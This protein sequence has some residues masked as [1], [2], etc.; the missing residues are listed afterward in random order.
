MA[1]CGVLCGVSGISISHYQI[2]LLVKNCGF[3]INI[4]SEKKVFPA[5]LY[6]T[7]INTCTSVIS[8]ILIAVL[9]HKMIKCHMLMDSF[10]TFNN[11]YAASTVYRPL[12]VRRW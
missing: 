4:F 1:W 5:S 9:P 2:S 10:R 3:W 8:I 12:G 11:H 6:S 7:L